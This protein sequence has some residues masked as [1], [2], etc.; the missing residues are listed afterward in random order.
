[1]MPSLI[2]LLSC[3]HNTVQNAVIL[4][5]CRY[6]ELLTGID[7][8]GEGGSLTSRTLILLVICC[9]YLDRSAVLHHAQF[10]KKREEKKKEIRKKREGKNR[11]KKGGK[12]EKEGPPT[13]WCALSNVVLT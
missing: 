2:R 6:I 9:V 13:A 8:L 7:F 1:M 10:T 12:K 4:M 3:L 5:I 11:W